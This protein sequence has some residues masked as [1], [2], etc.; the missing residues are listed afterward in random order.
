[1]FLA[2]RKSSL[3][4]RE[5]AAFGANPHAYSTP[6]VMY[7]NA[8]ALSQSV[9]TETSRTH[10]ALFLRFTYWSF[11]KSDFLLSLKFRVLKHLSGPE[12]HDDAMEAGVL[13]VRVRSTPWSP[14]ATDALSKYLHCPQTR[15]TVPTTQDDINE[16]K[17]SHLHAAR[18]QCERKSE[19]KI[20]C[21]PKN[22][23]TTRRNIGG[24]LMRT[25]IC[26]SVT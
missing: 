8:A 6:L 26:A 5:C 23:V 13:R 24:A 19:Q 25:T 10:S 7:R 9:P 2:Y 22:C 21:D 16:H 20:N 1:M 14:L 4:H 3:S 15:R 12:L 18:P 17:S 11:I